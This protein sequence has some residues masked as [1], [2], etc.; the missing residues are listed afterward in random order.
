MRAHCRFELE[1]IGVMIHI[2][3][4]RGYCR[5]VLGYIVQEVR[6]NAWMGVSCS[7]E[8]GNNE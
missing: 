4:V 5:Q 1:C 6:H 7:L 3:L 8:L 2:E